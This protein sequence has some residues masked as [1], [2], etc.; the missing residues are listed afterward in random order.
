[1]SLANRIKRLE[2]VFPQ[3][4]PR[5]GIPDPYDWLRPLIPAA[6]LIPAG[7]PVTA[8]TAFLT[9][10]FGLGFGS[11]GKFPDDVA[12]LPAALALFARC[13]PAERR[14]DLL[15]QLADG[16]NIAPCWVVGLARLQSRL[17]PDIGPGAFTAAL[18]THD[19]AEP[20][21]AGFGITCCGCG[22]VRAYPRRGPDVV[23]AEG[24]PNCGEGEW[25][26][27]SNPNPNPAWRE[28]A[29]AELGG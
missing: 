14:P 15:A 17:P 26:W 18:R 6:E 11:A 28:R 13:C 4:Q 19:D 16:A 20:A 23:G 24:C 7:Q 21:F 8:V 27:T 29:K 2:A 22:L 10:W 3:P 5:Q 1:M 12:R 25:E 9:H